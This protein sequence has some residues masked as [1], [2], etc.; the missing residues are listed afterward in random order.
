MSHS[1]FHGSSVRSSSGVQ[2]LRLR[3]NPIYSR[4]KKKKTSKQDEDGG[5]IGKTDSCNL[6]PWAAELGSYQLR[7]SSCQDGSCYYFSSVVWKKPRCRTRAQ[8]VHFSSLNRLSGGRGC[9]Q[10][11][12]ASANA[13]L[14]DCSSRTW[15]LRSLFLP[16]FFSNSN[17]RGKT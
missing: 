15:L 5:T 10:T 6:P 4:K 11:T 12:R 14:D 1:T 16:T 13:A 7:K 9:P 17:K 2:I 8:H 3:N